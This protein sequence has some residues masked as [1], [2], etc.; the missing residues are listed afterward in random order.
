MRFSAARWGGFFRENGPRHPDP[1][2]NSA[3]LITPEARDEDLGDLLLEVLP[4]D[5]STIG[6]MAARESLGGPMP[7]RRHRKP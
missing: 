3:T 5:R 2:T 6:N 7:L 4:P 1:V